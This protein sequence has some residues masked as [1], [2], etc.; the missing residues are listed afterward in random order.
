MGVT[1]YVKFN[2]A[3]VATGI[4][5]GVANRAVKDF[6]DGVRRGINGS[7]SPK[8]FSQARGRKNTEILAYPF[9]VDEDNQQGHYIMFNIYLHGK[10]E[11]SNTKNC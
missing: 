2:A 3:Q 8:A 6:A 7:V 9:N 10:G 4:A 5:A 11:T 1:N